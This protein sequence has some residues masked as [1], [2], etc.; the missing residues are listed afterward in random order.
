ML[1]A[2]GIKAYTSPAPDSP[3]ESDAWNRTLHSLREVLSTTSWYVH[4]QR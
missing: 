1:T 3:I 2:R 4:I